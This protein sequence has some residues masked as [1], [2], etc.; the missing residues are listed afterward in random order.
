MRSSKRRTRSRV[1]GVAGV[2]F[3]T[4]S[5]KVRVEQLEMVLQPDGH[6]F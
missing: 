4:V 1:V 6:P 3:F 5:W 2:A